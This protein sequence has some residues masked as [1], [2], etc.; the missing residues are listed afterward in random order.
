M[1]ICSTDLLTISWENK[2][3]EMLWRQPIG[4]TRQQQNNST[5]AVY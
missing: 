5:K 1:W 4:E 3:K 2:V